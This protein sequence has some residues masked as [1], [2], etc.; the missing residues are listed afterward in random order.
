M[1]Q[2]VHRVVL[3][4]GQ[5]DGVGLLMDVA[6]RAGLSCHLESDLSVLDGREPS[7]QPQAVLVDLASLDLGQR[8]ILIDREK[9]LRMPVVA[10]VTKDSVAG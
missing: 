2:S 1:D 8:R 3:L 6:E 10:V 7:Q 5:N 4:V 9:K